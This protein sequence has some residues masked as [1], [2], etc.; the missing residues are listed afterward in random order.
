[1]TKRISVYVKNGIN[2]NYRA[3]LHGAERIGA[4]KGVEI[5]SRL[6]ETPDDV[7]QQISLMQAELR[8]D[9]GGLPDG[10]LFNPTDDVAL[11]PMVA[12][13]NSARI[14]TI[15]FINRIA[16]TFVS[17]VGGDEFRIGQSAM[18]YFLGVLGNEGNI[19]IIEGPAAAPTARERLR[20]FHA[21]LG[22]QP[23]VNFAASACGHYQRAGGYQAMQRILESSTPVD[24]VIAANDLMALGALD[25]LLEAKRSMLVMGSNG[26]VEAAHAI[27]EGRLLASV[28]YDGFK[29]GCIATEAMLRHWNGADIPHEILMPATI[30][31]KDNC[32]AWRVPIELREPPVWEA[33][34]G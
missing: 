24:G 6:P 21:A 1:M 10:V 32:A 12:Q 11:M 26:T 19:A 8:G 27:H 5:I 9:L 22:E 16:G 2:P 3:F 34:I 28:D 15:N 13:L 33:V 14:P 7:D 30:V 4:A 20:G 23:K 18:R 17:F 29:M 25:A 31:H